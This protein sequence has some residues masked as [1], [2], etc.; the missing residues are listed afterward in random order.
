MLSG[1][2]HLPVKISFLAALFTT[3]RPEPRVTFLGYT[4]LVAHRWTKNLCTRFPVS[5]SP[6]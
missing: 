4:T 2:K 5:T 6:V 1:A 3:T